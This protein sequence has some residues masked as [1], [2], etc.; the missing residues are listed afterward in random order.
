MPLAT[1]LRV[2]LAERPSLMVSATPKA[3]LLGLLAGKTTRVERRLYC[4]VGLRLEGEH[5]RRRQLSYGLVLAARG[6]G[7]AVTFPLFIKPRDDS[8]RAQAYRVNSKEELDFFSGYVRNPIIQDFL[9]GPEITVDAIV[10]RSGD[11][12]RSFNESDSRSGPVRS[13]VA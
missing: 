2:C 3:S 8:G 7:A 4:M 10:G 13:A 6:H 9:I 11:L 1:W 5:G 12:L